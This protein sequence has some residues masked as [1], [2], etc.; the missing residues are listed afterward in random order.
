MSMLR[1][2]HIQ[3]SFDAVEVL[4]DVSLGLDAGEMLGL[5]GPN[6]A[7][8]T[9]L[10]KVLSGLLEPDRGAVHWG[11][12]GLSEVAESE[13][14]KLLAYLAQGAPAHWPL[15]V[16]KVV[17]L[18]RIPH[19]AWW[20]GQ[21]PE[22]R[23]AIETA[24]VNADVAHLRHRVVT[25]LSGG[26]RA[27]VLLARVFATQPRLVLADEP[28]ASL[29]PYHQLQVMRLLHEHALGGGGVLVVLHDLNLAARF[30][31]RLALLHEGQLVCE[32]PTREV[33]TNPAL[34]EAYGVAIDID[35]RDD[36]PWVRYR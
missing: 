25:T 10:L 13:R 24:L 33:L 20:Q 22:D 1:G 15:L 8:K 19:R 9:T 26:E 23:T 31:T 2:E 12:Q 7:G 29:D 5:I 17:E 6:G 34:S 30:C 35:D 4:R 27:R 14:G 11:D 3:V 16:E 21:Q 36:L 32:G 28:V 18:G